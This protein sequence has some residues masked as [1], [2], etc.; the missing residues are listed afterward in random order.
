MNCRDLEELLSAY[1]DDDL[2]RTQQ[3]FIEKH[4]SGC[5]HCRETLAKFKAAGQQLSSLK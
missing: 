5:V 3:E 1:A 4:L 2:S